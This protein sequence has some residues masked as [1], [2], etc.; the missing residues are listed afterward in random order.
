MV[1]DLYG[2]TEETGKEII[3]K[4]DKAGR[5]IGF[6]KLNVLVNKDIPVPLEVLSV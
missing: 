1:C 5:I 6:E 2:L 4:K 3:L